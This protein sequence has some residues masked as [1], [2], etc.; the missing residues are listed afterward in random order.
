L[1]ARQAALAAFPA[2][3]AVRVAAEAPEVGKMQIKANHLSLT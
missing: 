3:A 1:A 2:A